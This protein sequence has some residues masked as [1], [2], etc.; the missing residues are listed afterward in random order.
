LPALSGS[1]YFFYVFFGSFAVRIQSLTTAGLSI[2]FFAPDFI[3]SLLW[4]LIAKSGPVSLLWWW[5]HQRSFASPIPHNLTTSI[6]SFSYRRMRRTRYKKV[7]EGGAV[8]VLRRSTT[9]GSASP[10]F[11]AGGILAATFPAG[12]RIEVVGFSFVNQFMNV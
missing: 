3:A 10:A 2:A 1:F 7:G 4:L 9:C 11:P 8:F 6:Y 12:R 5:V